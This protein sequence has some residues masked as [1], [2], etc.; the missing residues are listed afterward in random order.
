MPRAFQKHQPSDFGAQT[1]DAYKA[2]SQMW[3]SEPSLLV[4]SKEA[5][6][7]ALIPMKYRWSQVVG[8]ALG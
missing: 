3:T 1:K 8:A 7:V 4:S 5:M 2:E 6:A